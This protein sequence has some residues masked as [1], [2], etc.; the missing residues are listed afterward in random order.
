MKLFTLIAFLCVLAFVGAGCSFQVGT[1][2][3]D[4]VK[5]EKIEMAKDNGG[6]PG[7]VV[8][9]FK[10]GETR[11]YFVVTLNG[12]KKD[13]KIKA[14][15]TAVE[16]GEVTNQKIADTELTTENDSQSSVNFHID[17]P[18]GFPAGTYKAEFFVDGKPAKTVDYKVE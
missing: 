17:L 4:E 15:F 2:K 14:T 7:D 12:G 18:A 1:P 16:A 6:K 11:Q 5:I 8:T 3:V 13:T 10:A 9:V